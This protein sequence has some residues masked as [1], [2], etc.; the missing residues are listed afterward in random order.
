[1]THPSNTYDTHAPADEHLY[2]AIDY[3]EQHVVYD[4]DYADCWVRTD[5]TVELA[6]TQ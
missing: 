3:D 5:T 4:V 6:D 2:I 1:M